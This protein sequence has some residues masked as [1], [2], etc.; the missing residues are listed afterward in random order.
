M[1]HIFLTI[2]FH[3]ISFRHILCYGCYWSSFW[4][5]PW[6]T[7]SQNIYRCTFGWPIY[8]SFCF[9]YFIIL[10]LFKN[11]L[12]IVSGFDLNWNMITI[13][14]QWYWLFSW[15]IIR[16]DLLSTSDR[17]LGGWWIG[18]LLSGTIAVLVSIPVMAFPPRLPGMINS[19]SETL[20]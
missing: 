16:L 19:T 1:Y 13:Y 14:L 20:I 7:V 5:C 8:V 17:W 18:F 4:L 15:L 10:K 11:W 2:F 12:T 3:M 6:W 9:N